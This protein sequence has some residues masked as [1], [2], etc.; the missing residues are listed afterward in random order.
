MEYYWWRTGG[1][2]GGKMNLLHKF[3]QS[4]LKKII[5]KY[6]YKFNDHR[7]YKINWIL[8]FEIQLL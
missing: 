1:P 4:S 8:I 7:K 5:S 6:V 3:G 2:V